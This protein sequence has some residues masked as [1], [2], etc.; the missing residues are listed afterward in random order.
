MQSQIHT[1][2]HSWWAFPGSSHTST[3]LLRGNVYLGFWLA[4]KSHLQHSHMLA[5]NFTFQVNQFST[6]IKA[7]SLW[8]SDLTLAGALIETVPQTA[9]FLFPWR[10]CSSQITKKPKTSIFWLR[11]NIFSWLQHCS[12]HQ[13][14][15]G[16]MPSQGVYW[17]RF[18]S[19]L[20]LKKKIKKNC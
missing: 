4:P 1:S 19:S 20:S 2:H 17:A 16:S 18:L 10:S 9:F 5:V 12:V 8:M 11:N 6:Q 14:V 13:K 15:A 3:L 7:F